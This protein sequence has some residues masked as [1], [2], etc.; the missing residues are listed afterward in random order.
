MQTDLWLTETSNHDMCPLCS[1]PLKRG[2]Q[3][4]FACGF[5]SKAPSVWIDPTVHAYQHVMPQ[6]TTE[7]LTPDPQ[8]AS[9]VWQYESP[10]F[11]AAGSLPMLSLFMS[12]APTQPQPPVPNRATT[13]RLPHVDEIDTAPPQLSPARDR[14]QFGTLPPGHGRT[15]R[16]L[17]LA[18][19][20]APASPMET[21]PQSWTAGAAVGS[22]SAQL[23]MH[24][25]RRKRV[26][27][28]TPFNPL[29]RTR[30]WLLH[31]G[32]IEFI[33]WLGGTFLLIGMTCLLLLVSAL[34]FQW[35]MPFSSSHSLS[36]NAGNNNTQQHSVSPNGTGP[37]IM[38]SDSS[39]L[40]PGQSFH[41]RGQGFKPSI[42]LA[43]YFDGKS[44]LLDQ[45][46]R[47]AWARVS[48]SGSFTATLWLGTG[49]GW[50]P[51]A[52]IISARDASGK[53][54]AT[55]PVRLVA[56][57]SANG[58][59]ASSSPVPG[60]TPGPGG[61]RNG[62]PITQGPQSTPVGRPP[63]TPTSAPV[64][65]TASPTHATPTVTPTV[66][67]SPTVTP[68]VKT[69]PTPIGSP[70]GGTPTPGVSP[71]AANTGL[72]N[73]LNDSGVPPVAERLTSILPLVWIMVACYLLSMLS[74]GAAGIIHRQHRKIGL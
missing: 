5:S 36:T 15:P 52:H 53:P 69:S 2:A 64:T 21:T 37:V 50:S 63:V 48:A 6:H 12:E 70:A 44:S 32:R 59:V 42:M 49:S 74:L 34:S 28:A 55:L 56:N 13:R 3:T 60:S 58:T 18:S 57:S 29:D 73:D 47:S 51:G 14:D 65:P 61:T 10:N 11:E 24:P 41:L 38:L 9:P 8:A 27:R 68:T 66:A 25:G 54:L 19:Q 1:K 35:I 17:I 26:P 62:T 33:F 39:S 16:A 71:T 22:P 7:N 23:I 43:F 31:P 4:C 30:W 46:H 40:A 20:T 67:T 45:G 72:G